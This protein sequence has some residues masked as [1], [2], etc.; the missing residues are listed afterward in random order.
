MVTLM[1]FINLHLSYK[2]TLRP[3]SRAVFQLQSNYVNTIACFS[4]VCF[5]SVCLLI[6]QK[7]TLFPEPNILL[8]S[9]QTANSCLPFVVQQ[10]KITRR[11]TTSKNKFLQLVS[12]LVSRIPDISLR[13][14]GHFQIVARIF[15][16]LCLKRIQKD[17]K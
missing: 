7:V 10:K 3:K 12:I 16:I 13:K 9:H 5:I 1:I 14:S 8:A 4:S 6:C 2:T 15:V 17:Y 11:T